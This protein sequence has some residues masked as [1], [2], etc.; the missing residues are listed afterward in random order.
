MGSVTLP[1]TEDELGLARGAQQSALEPWSVC[2]RQDSR[3]ED[4]GIESP[5]LASPPGSSGPAG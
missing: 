2:L 3:V 5:S 4:P 1:P